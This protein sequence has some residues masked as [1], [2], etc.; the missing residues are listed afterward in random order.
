MDT[1]AIYGTVLTVSLLVIAGIIM[2]Y[3]FLEK[4]PPRRP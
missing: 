1:L 3:D 2:I 4:Q